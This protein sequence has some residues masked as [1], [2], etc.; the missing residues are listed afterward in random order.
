MLLLKCLIKIQI[1]QVRP[2]FLNLARD[3]CL[4]ACY[5]DFE[6][7]VPATSLSDL[8]TF[9]ENIEQL[10]LQLPS[11]SSAEFFNLHVADWIL[12]KKSNK[13][14]KHQ[15]GLIIGISIYYRYQFLKKNQVDLG[16]PSH[17]R[18]R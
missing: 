17:E 4:L 18:G 5:D 13:A 11:S 10:P 14:K 2:Q 15:I 9:K 1:Y 8:T 16:G 3:D 6:E 7:L 12:I